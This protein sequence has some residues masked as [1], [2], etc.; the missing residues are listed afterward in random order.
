MPYVAPQLTLIGSAEG[1]VLGY[2]GIFD[3]NGAT[4]PHDNVGT[5]EAEW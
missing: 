5:L 1:V 4:P 2:V 3:D